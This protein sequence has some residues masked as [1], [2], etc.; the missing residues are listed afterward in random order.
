MF[1]PMKIVESEPPVNK[2]ADMDE[3]LK[4]FLAEINDE[5]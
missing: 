1:A 5:A 2:Q 3:D 4:R